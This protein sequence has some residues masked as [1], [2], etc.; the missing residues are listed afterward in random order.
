MC[1]YGFSFSYEFTTVHSDRLRTT[2]VDHGG[3]TNAQ[4]ASTVRSG[5]RTTHDSSVVGSYMYCRLLFDDYHATI[6]KIK[7][8]DFVICSILIIG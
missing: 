8:L 4:D 3:I 6:C 5:T 2:R 1:S 7:T